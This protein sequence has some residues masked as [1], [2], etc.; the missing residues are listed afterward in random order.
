M[1]KHGNQVV[2]VP[3]IEESNAVDTTGEG[4]QFTSGFLYGLVPLEELGVYKVGACS[5]GSVT[6]VLGGEVWPENWQW[7]YK[8]M[9]AVSKWQ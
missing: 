8:Q 4:N 3:A 9:H 2:Q 5:S 7:M 6:R 1:A